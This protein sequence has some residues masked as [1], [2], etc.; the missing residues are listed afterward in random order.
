MLFDLQL[1]FN[2][3]WPLRQSVFCPVYFFFYTDSVAR[4]A[5]RAIFILCGCKKAPGNLEVESWWTAHSSHP[6]T[7]PMKMIS[8][9][10][11]N[12]IITIW[13][14][15]PCTVLAPFNMFQHS[16][17]SQWTPVKGS[18]VRE[19]MVLACCFKSLNQ[20]ILVWMEKNYYGNVTTSY[21]QVIP[22]CLA[23]K[24]RAGSRDQSVQ[25]TAARPNSEHLQH[26]G[27]DWF[28]RNWKKKHTWAWY[29][30]NTKDPCTRL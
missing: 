18:S 3:K 23:A 8:Y 21:C 5:L 12:R 25:P 13:L 27:K 15:W 2:C 7:N 11:P 29:G 22:R 24:E 1:L 26:V 14:A 10:A 9:F 20:Q 4:T 6:R 19:W 17:P 30:Y 16:R 28:S